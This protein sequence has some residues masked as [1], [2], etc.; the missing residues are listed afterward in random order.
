M[1]QQR[2]TVEFSA[3][4]W[5]YGGKAA[6]Y[7]V[8][9]PEREAAEIAYFSQFIVGGKRAGWGLVRVSVQIG[10]TCWDTSIFPDRK[11]NSYLL[12][13]KAA[14][15]K[16]ENIEKDSIVKVALSMPMP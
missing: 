16:A 8:T 15:R 12:P 5:Y 3:P 9:L 1:V 4:C 11:R 14:V 13:I 6:W 10:K 2:H 7:F